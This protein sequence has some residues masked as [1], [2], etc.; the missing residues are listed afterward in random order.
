MVKAGQPVPTTDTAVILL[1]VFPASAL[2]K[3]DL[4]APRDIYSAPMIFPPLHS[5]RPRDYKI[6]SDGLLTGSNG[7]GLGHPQRA[8][9]HVS[10]MGI[11]SAVES[12]LTR[13]RE[14]H[15]IPLRGP[16]RSLVEGTQLYVS[17]LDARGLGF[18]IVVMS[19][20]IGVA[21]L[22]VRPETC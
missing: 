12:D 4:L 10:E 8:Y 9:T 19:S 13:G 14:N 2:I 16:H 11:V 5:E 20:L 7:K 15:F 18:P 22:S 17:A 1:Q 3:P 6:R 21:G